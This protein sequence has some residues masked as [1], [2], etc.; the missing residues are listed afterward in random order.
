MLTLSL[1]LSRARI[2]RRDISSKK[3][4]VDKL[5]VRETHRDA[6]DDIINRM[7]PDIHG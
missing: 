2:S 7:E 5:I 4:K 3:T 6:W 1:S